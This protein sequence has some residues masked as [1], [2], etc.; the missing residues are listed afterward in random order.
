[1]GVTLEIP[2]EVME[3]I[4]NVYLT[5]DLFFVNK[6]PFFITLSRKIDFNTAN[7]L[8]SRKI[9]E[10]FKA[11]KEI[12]KYYLQRGLRITELHADNEFAALKQYLDEMPRSPRLNLTAA[13]EHVPEIERR[14]RVVKERIRAVRH[15]LP[16]ERIPKLMTVHMVLHVVK[17][18]NYFPTKG[19]ISPQWSPRMI[20]SGKPLD[21]KKELA[22]QFGS[23]C[24]VHMHHAPRNSMKERTSGG[25]CL[26]PS[27]N[28]QGGCRFL[29]L[30]TGAKITAFKWT[31]LPMP[32]NVIVRVNHLGKDQPKDL[33]FYDRYG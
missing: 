33:T 29:H 12:Y 18:L 28:E 4:K 10:I 16:F 11:F 6:I 14:I 15:S 30:S 5:I 8:G 27:G 26:G 20:M 25:I 17:I 7:H 1:M 22:V 13:D 31:V 3:N 2:K 23:Y 9:Q 19:G 32:D 24:Q 21:Y